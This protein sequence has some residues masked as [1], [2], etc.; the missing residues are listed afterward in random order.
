M[1][2]FLN[3]GVWGIEIRVFR[4]FLRSEITKLYL[5]NI[6]LISETRIIEQIVLLEVVY[7][8]MPA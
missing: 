2:F 5:E 3:F 8:R 4:F 1:S 7:Y 6:L